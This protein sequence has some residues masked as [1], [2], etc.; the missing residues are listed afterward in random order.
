M[1]PR[2][3]SQALNAGPRRAMLTIFISSRDISDVDRIREAGARDAP[4]I[5][6]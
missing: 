4:N 5:E 2:E 6:A 1:A 3:L